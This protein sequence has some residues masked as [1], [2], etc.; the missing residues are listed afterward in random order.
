MLK[1]E[2]RYIFHQRFLDLETFLILGYFSTNTFSIEDYYHS[3]SFFSEVFLLSSGEFFSEV[4][5]ANTTKPD[6]VRPGFCFSIQTLEL[7]PSKPPK[8]P[9]WSMHNGIKLYN[10]AEKWPILDTLSSEDCWNL[11]FE[12]FFPHEV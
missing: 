8:L 9:L 3:F 5:P 11:D 4:S 6:L 1:L 12:F 7:K 10:E 2:P